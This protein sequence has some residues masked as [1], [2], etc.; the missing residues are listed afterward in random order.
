MQTRQIDLTDDAAAAQDWAV[1]RDALA[2]DAPEVPMWPLSGYRGYL[3]AEQRRDRRLAVGAFDGDRQVGS[4]LVELPLQANTEKLWFQL[5]VLP[6]QRRRG[7][8]TAL[9]AHLEGL[10]SDEGRTELLGGSAI[11]P[12]DVAESPAAHF[13]RTTGFSLANLEIERHLDLPVDESRL[14]E[15]SA[16]GADRR[17]GYR[18]ETFRDRVPDELVQSLCDLQNLLIVDAP[19]GDVEFEPEQSTPEDYVERRRSLARQRMTVWETLAIDADGR[20]VAQ[21]TLARSL[22]DPAVLRQ[23]GTYVHRDHRG[24][25]LG[26]ATKVANLR[27]ACADSPEAR[28]VGTQNAET[29]EWM[30]AINVDLGFRVVAQHPEWVRR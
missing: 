30:V 6:D 28:L 3:L 10:A 19:S 26:M 8:G 2:R 22:D 7:V 12:G 16:R 24:H 17:S 23:W 14:D 21:S 15:L 20:A 13:A 4:M 9:L 18:V 5:T 27:A 29:N 25:G 11:G 1:V